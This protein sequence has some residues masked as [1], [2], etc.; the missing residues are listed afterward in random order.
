MYLAQ[1]KPL[2]NKSFEKS[3][4]RLDISE[5]K[6]HIENYNLQQSVN[7]IKNIPDCCRRI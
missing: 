7:K 3:F 2:W 1:I 4:F 5:T 6:F